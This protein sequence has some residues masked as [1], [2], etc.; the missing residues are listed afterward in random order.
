MED[1]RFGCLLNNKIKN[2]NK[3][4]NI[5]FN[6]LYFIFCVFNRFYLYLNRI[7]YNFTEEFK[8]EIEHPKTP[9]RCLSY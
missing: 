8:T 4:L 9:K 5:S 1:F 2:F 3:Y 7:K 6:L